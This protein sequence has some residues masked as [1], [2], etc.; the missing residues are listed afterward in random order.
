ME[1]MRRDLGIS[2]SLMKYGDCDGAHDAISD[3][4]QEKVE[5]EAWRINRGGALLQ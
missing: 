2:F 4:K 5:Y 3:I 1:D